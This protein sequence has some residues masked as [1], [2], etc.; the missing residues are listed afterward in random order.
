MK[1]INQ[2][3]WILLITLFSCGNNNDVI[4]PEVKP[5]LEG[6]YASGYIVSENEYQV[7]AQV[8]GYLI[9]SL[10]KEGD[11]VQTGDVLF[12]IEAEQQGA[13]NKA[14]QEVYAISL[15][16]YRE[17]SPVI[18]ELKSL[19]AG[20]KTK[21]SYDSVNFVRYENLL[22]SNATSKAEYDR[23]KLLYEN[24][25]NDYALQKSRY[26]KALNQVYLEYQNAKSQLQ[27]TQNESGKYSVRSD[28]NGKVYRINKEKGELVRRSEVL[29]VVGGSVY[30]LQLTIDE[31]DIQR[32]EAGQQILV[33]IDAY[34][35]QIFKAEVAKIYPMVNQQQQS[36]RV[37]AILVDK[38]PGAF[39][40]LA[41][42]ANIIIRQ[43]DK[44]LVIPKSALLKGDSLQ[45]KTEDGIKKI[46]VL[47]G[48]KTFDEVEIIDGITDKTEI[49]KH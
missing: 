16:N 39:T 10:V 3:V 44:A 43:K 49:I 34:P 5:L 33:K 18:S 48:I 40:G 30:Y 12:R 7:I 41:V 1:G 24:S 9:E 8:E 4:I 17:G 11:S 27:I 20:A 21:L 45:I 14:A 46:K 47:T 28:V 2:F 42:E 35:E 22:K 19:V 25:S 37:D 13:R 29:A 15:K 36:I 31:L 26:Q 32:V 6:V 38:L 23:I